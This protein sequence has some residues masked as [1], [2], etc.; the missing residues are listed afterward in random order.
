MS[1]CA[2]WTRV[3]LLHPKVRPVA[4]TD[5]SKRCSLNRRGRPQNASSAG[6][7]TAGIVRVPHRCGF[8]CDRKL[9]RRVEQTTR[10]PGFACRGEADPLFRYS[11]HRQ[12]SYAPEWTSCGVCIQRRPCRNGMSGSSS[13]VAEGPPQSRPDQRSEVRTGESEAK[14]GKGGEDCSGEDEDW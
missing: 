3:V 1:V 5:A 6:I 14:I 12:R 9:R 8:V 4:S 13:P 7:Q 10:I 11:P 2:S